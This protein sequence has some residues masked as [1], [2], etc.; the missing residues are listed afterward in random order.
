MTCRAPVFWLGS[1]HGRTRRQAA[2]LLEVLLALGLFVAAAAVATTALNAA[3]DSLERQRRSTQAT[4][5]AASALAELQLGVRPLASASARPLDPPFQDW[6][7]QIEVSSVEGSEAA[8][9]KLVLAEVI[10]R[11]PTSALSRRL[12][13]FLPSGNPSTA[14]LPGSDPLP[15]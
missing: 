8:A 14:G 5:H 11:H 13:E 9:S 2:V 10:I 12:A 7:C 4:Q 3:L 6:T 1:R 15:P